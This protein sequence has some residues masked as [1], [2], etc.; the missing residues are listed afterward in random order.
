M[1][2]TCTDCGADFYREPAETWKKRCL[3]CWKLSKSGYKTDDPQ[4]A[5]KWYRKGFEAGRD[6][7][8]SE[9]RNGSATIDAERVRQLLQL[10]H[11]DKHGGSALATSVTAWLLEIRKKVT[12]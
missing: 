12:A 7:A 11:P 1:I 8:L 9:V 2:V 5:A 3:D 6:A 10:A 4:A